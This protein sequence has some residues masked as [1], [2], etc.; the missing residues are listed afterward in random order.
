MNLSIAVVRD[1]ADPDGVGRVKVALTGDAAPADV[2]ARVAAPFAGDDRGLVLL[3]QIGDEVLIGF[4]DAE[5]RVPVVLGALWNGSDRPPTTNPR[6]RLLRSTDG[7]KISLLDSGDAR[8]RALVI[9]DAHGSRV[10][11]RQGRMMIRAAGALEIEATEVT[12]N[13][14]PLQLTPS[15]KKPVRRKAL[16]T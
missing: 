14:Q 15:P 16:G 13:G 12:V 1:N 7:H 6:E 8:E 4:L 11:M 2:W 5:G 9:E 10:E 3:P